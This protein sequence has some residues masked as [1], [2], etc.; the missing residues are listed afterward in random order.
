M[1]LVD[2]LLSLNSFVLKIENIPPRVYLRVRGLEPSQPVLHV[3]EK[4]LGMHSH[5][6]DFPKKEQNQLL[7]PQRH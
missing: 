1:G 4:G 3:L 2:S 5:F 6:V 7:G